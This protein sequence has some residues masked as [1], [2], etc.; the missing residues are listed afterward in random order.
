MSQTLTL[1][2]LL[3]NDAAFIGVSVTGNAVLRVVLFINNCITFSYT[4]VE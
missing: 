2:G 4:D 1:N 3:K